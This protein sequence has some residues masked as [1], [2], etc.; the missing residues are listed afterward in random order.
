MPVKQPRKKYLA[1]ILSEKFKVNKTVG[2]NNNHIGVP[3]TILSTNEKHK[4]LV[5]ELGTNHFG[6]ITLYCSNC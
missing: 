4:V 3:L 6:E 2:N 1:T 5:A